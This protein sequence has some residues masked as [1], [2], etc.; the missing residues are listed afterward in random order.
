MTCAICWDTM[1]MR[2]F[3][4]PGESTSTCFKIECG[5]AFHTRC[6]VTCLTAGR[7]KCPLCNSDKP[8]EQELDHCG[9]AR[10]MLQEIM[11]CRDVVELRNELNEAD[12]E[13]KALAKVY[14]KKVEEY[15]N[16][17]ALE[18]KLSTHREYYLKC[19]NATRGLI[20]TKCREVGNR[21]LGAYYFKKSNYDVPLVDKMLTHENRYWRYWRRVHSRRFCISI[22]ISKKRN[23]LNDSDSDGGDNA[24]IRS[25]L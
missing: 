20:R 25:R 13:L 8:P 6:L 24:T 7:H 18:M 10:K 21:H 3:Q 12:H 23:E 16:E 4:D 5:H 15:A 22:L 1:D 17:L 19:L 14:R 2:E 9:Y 11:I